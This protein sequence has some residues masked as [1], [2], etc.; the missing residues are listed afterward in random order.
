MKVLNIGNSF[1]HD[2]TDLL[3]VLSEAGGIDVSRISVYEAI[4][5]GGSFRNWIDIYND[6]DMEDTY[7]ISRVLGGLPLD[8]TE[9]E[10]SAGDGRLF[11][12]TLKAVDWDLIIINQVSNYAPY[13]GSWNAEGKSGGLDSFIGIIRKEQP[14][15]HL[16]FLL[17]HSYWDGYENNTERSSLK[18]W[19]MIA[20]SARELKKNYPID[21]IV[22]YGTAIENMR[23]SSLNN[24]YDL[25]ADGSHCVFS[26]GHYTAACCYYEAVIAPFTGVSVMG[27]PARIDASRTDSVYPAVSVTDENAPVAQKAAILAVKDMFHCCNPETEQML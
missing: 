1:T 7:S 6:D 8:I 24:S 23:S 17:V 11:R 18:R 10:A 19:N 27:N 15:A 14:E 4:R 2:A 9:G 26:I 22:P 21:I 25:T 3:S 20:Q 16:G 12:N 5:R 13:F